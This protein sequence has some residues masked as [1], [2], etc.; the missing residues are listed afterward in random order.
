M[1][2]GVQIGLD[3]EKIGTRF[4]G[5]ETGTGDINTVGAGEMFYCGPDGG[6]EL[7]YFGAGV[8]DNLVVDDD[9][10]FE[11]VL[12]ENAFDGPGGNPNVVGVENPELFD[13]SEVAFVFSGN[14][15]DFEE[16]DLAVVIDDCTTLDIRLGLVSDFHDEFSA[17]FDHVFEDGRIDSCPQIV[18]I[19]DEN[20]VDA[21]LD[22]F[23]QLTAL[24]QGV[25]DVAVAWRVPTGL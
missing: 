10:E 20:V 14:L 13:G 1:L 2:Q 8:L 15:G 23:I 18:D 5:E 6:F 16:A 9:I 7:D 19:G 11:N 24:I 3:E 21:L 25:V 4:D 12:V 22:E 17:S